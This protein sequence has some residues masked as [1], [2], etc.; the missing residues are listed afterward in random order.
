MSRAGFLFAMVLL[1][2]SGSAGQGQRPRPA[3]D[4]FQIVFF[5]VLSLPGGDSLAR[6]DVLYRIDQ[7]FFISSRNFDPN[8]P[9]TFKRRGETVL[10]V[11]NA[12]GVSAAREIHR[13]EIDAVPEK[14]EESSPLWY[15]RVRTFMVPPGTY[16]VSLEINDLESERRLS[17]RSRSVEAR[18]FTGDKIVT[19]SPMFVTNMTD[20]AL[21]PANFGG[22]TLIGGKGGVFVQLHLPPSSERSQGTIY[23]SL[24]ETRREKDSGIPITDTTFSLPFEQ[25]MVLS[26]GS[27]GVY[28]LS[29]NNNA[30]ISSVFIPLPLELLRLRQ[31][32]LEVSISAGP[33]S[34]RLSHT[35]R[36]I[37]P[38][39]PRSLRNVDM[40]LDALRFITRKEELDSLK[41][42]TFE[43]RI[44]NLEDFWKP[45]DRTPET[46]INETMAE[47]YRRVDHAMMTFGTLREPDG[48]RND[49][50]RTYIL[51]GPPT[52]IDRNLDTE[53]AREIWTYERLRKRFIFS[54][55]SRT[56]SYTL[57]STQSF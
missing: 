8:A 55:K 10:E 11:L 20:S 38:G 49:R 47:Y 48:T 39:M 6:L 41:K 29:R 18:H 54:D 5:E 25:E 14:K 31:F 7:S 37:W 3:P 22:N 19:S 26:P 30:S 16:S 53:E 1:L 46:A 40:A 15:E 27:Q 35:F 51:H 45:K 36:T 52:E 44:Q 50:G 12:E 17:Q 33:D 23:Y 32:D 13:I 28:S 2:S 34:V 43:I 9:S 4:E 56:G 24:R 21:V 57:I 42:G